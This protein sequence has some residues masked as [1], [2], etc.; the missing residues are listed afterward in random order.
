MG[1]VLDAFSAQQKQLAISPHPLAML[2]LPLAVA[3]VVHSHGEVVG[4][5]HTV[6]R[7]SSMLR[8]GRNRTLSF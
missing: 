6:S 5:R 7:E 3:C 1:N 2:Q 8:C 4:H